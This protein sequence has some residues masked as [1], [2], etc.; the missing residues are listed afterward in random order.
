MAAKRNDLEP[1]LLAAL[2]HPLRLRIMSAA[3][4]GFSPKRLADKFGDVSVQLVSYHVRTLREAGLIELT[5][6]AQRRGAVEHFYSAAPDAAA[7]VGALGNALSGLSDGLK[8][9]RPKRA[10]AKRK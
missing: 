6:T 9:K 8:T 5:D 2:A 10:A 7:R 3:A 4:E 1:E